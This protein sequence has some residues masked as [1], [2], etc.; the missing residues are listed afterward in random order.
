MR[1]KRRY[2]VLE[3]SYPTWLTLLGYNEILFKINNTIGLI[4]HRVIHYKRRKHTD[5]LM[6]ISSIFSLTGIHYPIQ[7]K[8]IKGK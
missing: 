4:V 3:G 2:K 6:F 5:V 8:H 7:I 1:M